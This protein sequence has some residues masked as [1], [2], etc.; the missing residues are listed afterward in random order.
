MIRALRGL[1]RGEYGM[2]QYKIPDLNKHIDDKHAREAFFESLK[3]PKPW[4]ERDKFE[5]IEIP[6]T[7][8]PAVIGPILFDESMLAIKCEQFH[9]VPNLRCCTI[10]PAGREALVRGEQWWS[11]LTF[12]QK[13]LIVF[14]E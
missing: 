4:G 12:F 7:W 10:T 5:F 9:W 6:G 14:S 11:S 3:D 8:F 13:M 2:V 1:A